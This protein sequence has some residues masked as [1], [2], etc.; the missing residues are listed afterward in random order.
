MIE[1]EIETKFNDQPTAFNRATIL[2]IIFNRR[3]RVLK[4]E[5]LW[6][7]RPIPPDEARWRP[8]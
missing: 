1:F 8:E 3:Y 5:G 6:R 4:Y 7:I 2:S